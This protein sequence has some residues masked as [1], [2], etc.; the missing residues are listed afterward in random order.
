MMRAV[1]GKDWLGKRPRELRSTG[2]EPLWALR[3]QFHVLYGESCLHTAKKG[4]IQAS[5]L[6][7]PASVA[8]A[9]SPAAV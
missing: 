3:K 6:C 1:A 8:A 9:A 4:R 7:T 5:V 2:A